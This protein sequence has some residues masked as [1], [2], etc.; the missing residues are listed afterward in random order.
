[1]T[2]ELPDA[3]SRFIEATNSG[4]TPAFLESFAVDAFLS[5]WGRD[6]IGREQIAQ[7]NQTDNIGQKSHLTIIQLEQTGDVYVA[8]VSVRGGGFNGEGKMTFTVAD[9][10]IARLIIS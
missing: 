4:N 2:T 10:A 1:M 5:D 7:W 6:F 8:R 3:I 9:G